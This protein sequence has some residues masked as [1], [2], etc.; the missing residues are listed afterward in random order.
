MGTTTR[1]VTQPTTSVGWRTNRR[2]QYA[3]KMTVVYLCLAAGGFFVSVPF[4]WMLSTSLKTLGQT[5]IFPPIWIPIPLQWANYVKVFEVLPFMRY[6]I[7]TVYVSGLSVAG[8]L[9]ASSLAGFSFARLRWR[10]STVLFVVV[11]STM[12]LPPQVTM[13]PKFILFRILEWIDTYKPLIVPSLFGT[14]FQIFLFRQFFS[15]IPREIDEAARMDGCG[16][17]GTYAPHHS[18]SVGT[19]DHH[20]LPVCLPVQLE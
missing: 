6:F 7:N 17:V 8:I 10:G 20:R 18:A 3:L 2:V 5:F 11:L 16:F 1:L 9:F 4:A 15:T 14:G 12:M 13:I 19:R